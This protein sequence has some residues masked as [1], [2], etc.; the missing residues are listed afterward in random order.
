MPIR[1]EVLP[2]G[3]RLVLAD[4]PHLHS[5]E[6]ACYVAV[7]GRNEP[8]GIGGISHFVEHML[9]RGCAGYDDSIA[10]ERAFEEVGG[11]VNAT[12]DAETTC[13]FSR[14]HP[15]RLAEGA[16]LFS[17]LLRKPLWNAIETERKII[18]EE[19]RED[20]SESGEIINADTL[21]NALLWPGHPL[22]RPLIGTEASLASIDLEALRAYHARFYTPQNTV[23]AVAGKLGD[24]AFDDLSRPFTDWQGALAPPAEDVE[25]LPEDGPPR[26]VWVRDSSSQLNLQF[27]LQV[28]FGRSHP[29]A[30][31]LRIWRRILSWGGTSRLML[32]LREELALTYHVEASLNLL[33]DTGCLTIDLAILPECLVQTVAEVLGLLSGMVTGDVGEEER[34]RTLRNFRYDLDYSRDIPEELVVRYGWGEL[35]GYRR[36]FERDLADAGSLTGAD[37]RRVAGDILRPGRLALAVVGPWRNEDRPEVDRLLAGW[38]GAR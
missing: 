1:E 37:L 18:L 26:S 11:A 30:F 32:R 23:I 38:T 19:A 24:S 36:S 28:P 29:D 12:T 10:L 17:R 13:F 22:G 20:L 27:A 21:T 14:L 3:L 6:M 8:A 16:E 31:A 34:R 2:N 7:G 9:F 25:T 4:M 35:V 33:G 15:E 5:L